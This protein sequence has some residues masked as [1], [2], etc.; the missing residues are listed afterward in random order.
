MKSAAS[1]FVSLARLALLG[2]VMGAS[3]LNLQAQSLR[4]YVGTYTNGTK[5]EGI[6]RFDL[7]PATGKATEPAVAAKVA[8]PS[9]LAIHKN[10]RNVYSVNEIDNQ[11]GKKSG[12]LTAFEIQ[13][14]GDLKQINQVETGGTAPCH[15]SI[16][17]TGRFVLFA[18]YGGGSSGSVSINEDGSLGKLTAFVQ[19]QGSSEDANRQQGPHAHS[20]NF[21]PDGRFAY[22]A[23]LGLD[24]VLIF[25]FDSH[26]GA[27][28]PANP[29]YVKIK[30][31]SG[32]RHF[33]FAPGG[34]RAFV[35]NEMGNTVVA[36]DVN[37]QTG[38]LTE[39]QTIGTLPPDFKGTSYT[40]EVVVHPNGHFVYGSNRGYHSI[41][42]F[43]VEPGGSLKYVGNYMSK[44]ID[45]PRNFNVDP[46][47]HWMLIEGQNTGLIEVHA[48]DA[49]TGQ[50]AGK[51]TAVVN[52]PTPVCVKFLPLK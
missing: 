22:V 13:P 38:E 39:T 16:D 23:D 50:P 32:P 46:S 33:A 40:A 34:K 26:T 35:I 27:M 21:S 20:G 19:H 25:A 47:G 51:A 28:T 43:T 41:T 18:N 6:Y 15:L 29:P 49:K 9:F 4:V 42:T 37:Q 44:A 12:G 45:T 1:Q 52:V 30:P 11:N 2:V 3:A 24:K 14:N 36:F 17:P 8:N 31:K 5:S 7:D 10:G 48:I